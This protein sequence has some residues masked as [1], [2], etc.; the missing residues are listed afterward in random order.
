LTQYL[1]RPEQYKTQ[2]S[3]CKKK[4]NKPTGQKEKEEE[5]KMNTNM[6]ELNI[7]ELEQVSG[8]EPVTLAAIGLGTACVCLIVEGIKFGKKIYKDVT[9]K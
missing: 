3:E 2:Y 4:D 5:K 6:K 1:P 9:S 7:N 8:G